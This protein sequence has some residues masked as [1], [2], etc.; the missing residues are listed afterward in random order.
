M[1]GIGMAARET[2]ANWGTTGQFP[3]WIEAATGAETQFTYNFSYGLVS[4]QTD[5]N[6]L[7]TSWAYNDGFGRLTQETR[8]DSTYTTWGYTLYSGTDPTP[9]M[10]MTVQPHDTAGHVISTTTQELDMLDRPYLTQ[11]E[12]IDGSTDTIMQRSYDAL[13]RVISDQEPYEGATVGAVTYS[14]DLLNHLYQKTRT[15]QGGTATTTYQHAGRTTAIED[16]DGNAKTLVADVNGWLRETKDATGYAIILG[17]DAAGSHVL[18]TDNQGNGPSNPL[19]SGTVAYGI[20]PFTTEAADAD[21]GTWRYTIDALGEPTAWTDAKAQ[22]F[23]A[24]YDALSRMTDRYEPDL[25]SHWTWGTSAAAHNIGQLQSACTGTGVSPTVCSSSGYSESETYDLA[26]RPYQRSITI[27]ADA[28]YTYTQTYNID[29]LPDT[30]TYPVSTSGYALA[31]KYGYAYGLLQSITATSESP[32]VTLWTANTMDAFG[33]YSKE[34]LGNGVVVNHG[35]DPFRGLPQSITAGVGGGAALQDNS[36]LFDAVGNL[37]ERQDINA[38]TTEN[39]HYDSLNRL[40]YTVGDTNTQMSYDAMDRIATWE[41]SGATTNVN[42]YTTQQSGCTYYANAQPHAVREDTQG[43]FNVSYCYDAN[44]NLTTESAT[45]TVL[46]STTWT[47]FN[48][49]AAIVFGS[50]YSDLLYDQNH[51]RFEQFASYSGS[52]EVTEYIGGL[53]EKMTNSTGTAYRYYIP[54][55]NNFVVYN[56]WTN[57]TNAID[58]ATR[59]N[60][61]STAVI[62]D[63]N[64]A[65]LVAAKFA[66]LGMTDNTPAQQATIASVTRHKFT[67][68][69]GLDSVYLVDMNG[70]IYTSSGSRFISPDPRIPN[71]LNTLDYDRYTYASDNPLTYN[72]PTGFDAQC[73]SGGGK[74]DQDKGNIQQGTPP[75]PTPPPTEPWPGPTIYVPGLYPPTPVSLLEIYIPVFSETFASLLSGA[76]GSGSLAG[77]QQTDSCSTPGVYVC[78]QP[79]KPNECPSGAQP[80]R[81]NNPHVGRN[82]AGG[83]LAF[84]TIGATIYTAVALA[85]MED[86]GGEFML[87]LRAAQLARNGE[88]MVNTADALTYLARGG[89][90]TDAGIAAFSGGAVAA[91]FGAA[92]GAYLTQSTCPVTGS[93]G[94]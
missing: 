27:P 74:C 61:D 75:G 23:S 85:N 45:G 44:G 87:A 73:G 84:G 13:G 81:Q 43:A 28:T 21:L 90:L 19:W 29:G 49:P 5:P 39:V 50:G 58:Y 63:K 4:S 67:G 42:N 15:I 51:Q 25:Y 72:D 32:N 22:N 64:G 83:M 71:P 66:A 12:L 53:T 60:I 56:R 36:Y 59:D 31:L 2:Q 37:I 69:E 65:L 16:A 91:P 6:G 38:G 35:F 3:M 26:G 30:L 11:T 48:Q 1:T 77:Q 76:V 10:V 92:T 80:S 79:Q 68:Q 86:G 46:R 34:T 18:T 62:T 55:G 89:G 94:K 7:G 47:S 93:P 17:Y 41:L 78:Q 54:A 82:I 20:G 8:P 9:R 24:K 70:R 33:Q 14:Y 52:Q 88:T 40:G 57:G